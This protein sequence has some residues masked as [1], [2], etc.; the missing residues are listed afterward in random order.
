M[1]LSVG[2]QW[3]WSVAG[4][5]REGVDPL[6]LGPHTIFLVCRTIEIQKDTDFGYFVWMTDVEWFTISSLA[7]LD[8]LSLQNQ[9]FLIAPHNVLAIEN[10]LY[11]LANPPLFR[12]FDVPQAQ[13]RAKRRHAENF[14][15][16]ELLRKLQGQQKIRLYSHRNEKVS[17]RTK[18][19]LWTMVSVVVQGTW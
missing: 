13:R 3:D 9:T 12:N 8:A 17:T 2:R 5:D 6:E 7:M 19:I 18:H 16:L 11:L 4:G 10:G 14:I 15:G 1:I